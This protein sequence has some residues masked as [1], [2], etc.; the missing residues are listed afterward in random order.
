M[1]KYVN[2]RFHNLLVWA[3]VAAVS[4]LSLVY[5]GWQLFEWVVPVK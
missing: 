4:V 1:G 5:I 3:I 2:G